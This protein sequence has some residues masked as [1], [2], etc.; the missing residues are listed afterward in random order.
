M[1]CPETPDGGSAHILAGEPYM[2]FVSEAG[3]APPDAA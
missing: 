1:L 2:A 3:E